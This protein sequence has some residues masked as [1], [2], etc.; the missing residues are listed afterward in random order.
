MENLRLRRK[1]AAIN[2]E[3]FRVHPC[4][5][6]AHEQR[7]PPAQALDKKQRD[8]RPAICNT[9][10]KH[11]RSPRQVMDGQS[12]VSSLPPTDPS[13]YPPVQ[14]PILRRYTSKFR[15][16]QIPPLA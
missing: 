11:G 8:A 7:A 5:R 6:A 14:P 2:P 12:A 4:P 15:L 3:A 16:D 13:I 9:R 10:E 1:I